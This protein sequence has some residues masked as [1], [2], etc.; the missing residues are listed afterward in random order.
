MMPSVGGEVRVLRREVAAAATAP[1][2]E[3]RLGKGR[4][5]GGTYEQRWPDSG[6]W[7]E[8]RRQ[9]Q[10]SRGCASATEQGR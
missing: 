8:D 7:T 10:S 3:R 4:L 5:T 2:G 6:R 9:L 1:A